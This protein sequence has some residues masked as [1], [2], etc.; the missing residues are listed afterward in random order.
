V[1]TPFAGTDGIVAVTNSMS[2]TPHRFFRVEV[3]E[4]Q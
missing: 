1:G 4:V 2:A 3:L